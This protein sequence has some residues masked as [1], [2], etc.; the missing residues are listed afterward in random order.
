MSYSSSFV[1]H[2]AF[3]ADTIWGISFINQPVVSIQSTQLAC[4]CNAQMQD[5]E[6][7][8]LQLSPLV[9][10]RHCSYWE[11]FEFRDRAC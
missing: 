11:H 3:V 8:S 4:V 5:N 10:L 2:A 6:G 9:L 1:L 7:P